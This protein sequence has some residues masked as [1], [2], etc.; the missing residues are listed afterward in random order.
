MSESKDL[1]DWYFQEAAKTPLLSIEEE[2]ELVSQMKRWTLN[3]KAGQGT[4][5]KG[6]E[7]RE[8]LIKANLRLV[9]KIANEYKGLGLDLGDLI[10][11]GNIGLMKA[12]DKYKSDKGAKLSYY[13]SFWIRQCIT[14]GL[15]NI[16]RTIRLPTGAIAQKIKILKFIEKYKDLNRS[17]PDEEDIAKELGL[18]V[19]RVRL[20]SEAA[21]T[22][23]SINV[24]IATDAGDSDTLERGDLI[25]DVKIGS[26]DVLAENSDTNAAIDKCLSK[27]K[28]RE[29]LIVER[30][31]GLGNIK[32]ETLE[33]IGD[34]F[35][36]TRE[37]I[38]Q[39]ET[40]ALR[41]MSRLM[42]RE[43]KIWT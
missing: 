11:E 4:R 19:E 32:S 28:P 33:S 42:H 18:S 15:S 30:R 29:R 6:M 23:P 31:F 10:N 43:M 3:P 5:R 39:I 24:K 14:R 21:F 13:A 36:L 17:E 1:L 27:L 22:L 26:P 38:R 16:G 35:G 20:L 34:D 40:M 8:T 41:K 2:R 37:R 25:E 9:V 7:A 12:V